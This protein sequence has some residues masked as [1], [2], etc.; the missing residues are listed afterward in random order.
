[1]LKA[2]SIPCDEPVVYMITFLHAVLERNL[3]ELVDVDQVAQKVSDAGLADQFEQRP[4]ALVRFTAV[5]RALAEERVPL[6]A[7]SVLAN[8]FMR[9]ADQPVP[10]LDIVKQL[11]GMP[12]IKEVLPGNLAPVRYVLA[13]EIVDLLRTSIHGADAVPVL[14]IDPT[15]CQQVL[16]SI[17]A[18]LDPTAACTLVCDA[19][20]RPFVRKLVELEWPDLPVLAVDELLTPLTDRTTIRFE[21]A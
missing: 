1:V 18:A 12:E 2:K 8:A 16:T 5:L 10:T 15:K 13:Q 21:D 7:M 19:D 3:H 6:R 11:R 4:E 20:L 9:C 14:A 17:R